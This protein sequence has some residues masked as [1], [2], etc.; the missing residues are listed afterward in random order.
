MSR[1]GKG[2]DIHIRKWQMYGM[3]R[4]LEKLSFHGISTFDRSLL[5]IYT[6][7]RIK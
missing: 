7:S 4:L 3:I 1:I 5:M 2:Y 6:I